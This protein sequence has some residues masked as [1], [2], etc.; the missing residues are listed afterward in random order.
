MDNN[1]DGLITLDDWKASVQ[2]SQNNAK[3]RELLQFIRAKRYNLSKI[4]SILG[5]EGVRKVSVFSLKN[6]LMKL[7]SNLSE[8]N[9]LLLSK[10][11]SKG[12]EEV[13]VEQ[14]IDTLNLKE[15]G[16]PSDADEEWQARFFARLKRKLTDS[17]LVEE[18]LANRFRLYDKSD[19]GYIEQTDFKTVL[20]ELGVSISLTE[21]IKLVKFVPLN[22]QNHLRYQYIVDQLG[23]IADEAREE[24]TEQEFKKVIKE[25]YM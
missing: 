22:G 10:Y 15:D 5:L 20:A 25:N 21:L 13:D 16:V 18:E 1:K 7:W 4:L 12:R 6:G 17:G 3:F 14:I 2:F 11:I 23:F 19:S 24:L 9:A 8:D